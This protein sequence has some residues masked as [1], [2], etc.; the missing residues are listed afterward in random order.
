MMSL[1]QEKVADILINAE[2][3]HGAYYEAETFRGPSLYFHL[4]AL[5]TRESADF[6]LHVEY[7]YATLASWGMHRMG[8]RGSKM[9]P[10]GTFRRSVESLRY[11][12]AEAQQFTPHTMSSSE[13]TVLNDV[14]RGIKVMASGTSLVGNSKVMHHMMPNI[15]PPIDRE[16]R[17]RYLRGNSNISNDLDLEWA[18]MKEIIANFFIP[19]ACD[20]EC[21]L[22]AT[23]WMA[24]QSEYPWDTSLFK[25]VD[26]LVIGARRVPSEF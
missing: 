1:Y 20:A 3:Y 18:V 23:K 10:F 21:K 19:I 17:L 13:W 9:Q 7:V 2:R 26:N 15:V 4:R 12:I 22:K 11:R 25:V 16:Y 8:K 6:S 24:S 14:F 5:E